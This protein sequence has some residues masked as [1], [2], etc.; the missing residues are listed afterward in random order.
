MEGLQLR[1]FS[2]NQHLLLVMPVAICTSLTRKITASAELTVQLASLPPMPVL[3]I[4]DFMEMADW[5]Q[6]H[7]L[8]DQEVLLLMRKE[9]YT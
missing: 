2:M 1:P 3:E 6:K 8:M 7:I 9:T 4:K 5:R